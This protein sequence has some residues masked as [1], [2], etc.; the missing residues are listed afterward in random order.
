MN[1]QVF[2]GIKEQYWLYIGFLGQFLFGA[3]FLVQWVCS[4][5]K[6]ESYMPVVFWYFSLSGGLIL[7][8]YSIFKKDPVFIVGQSMGLIVYLRNI[9]L[10]F[11]KKKMESV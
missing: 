10:I 6:Q 9:R 8:L 5:I 7:L 1:A 4:E 3:R 2:W 11:K